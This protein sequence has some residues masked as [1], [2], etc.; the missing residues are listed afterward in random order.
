MENWRTAQL[1][2]DTINA[3]GQELSNVTAASRRP[4]LLQR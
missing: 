2:I 1:I 3:Y 4:E